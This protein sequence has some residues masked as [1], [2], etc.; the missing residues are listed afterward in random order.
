MK[1]LC[2][3]SVISEFGGVEYA[4]MN[5]ARGL[6]DRGHEVHF[7]GAQGQRTNLG[8]GLDENLTDHFDELR[9]IWFHQRKFP[10][11]FR[12]GE[13]HNLADKVIWH[14]RDVA[15]PIN[16]RIFNEVL[17]QVAPDVIVL[18]NLTAV[19]KNIWRPIRES[20]IPCM[21]WV[22]DLGLICFNMS[23]FRHGKQC[24]GLCTACR[25]QKW[26]RFS[27]ISGAKNFAFVAPSY[28]TLKDTENYAN[29]A[30]WRRVVIP[31]PNRYIVKPRARPSEG[32]SPRLLYVGRLDPSKGVEPMLHAAE[33]ARGK[34]KFNLDVLGAG[35]IGDALI[36]K[37]S[38]LEWIKFHG[39]VDQ[40][41]VA[42]FMS[43]AVALLVPSVWREAYGI[44]AA[45]ALFAGLPVLASRI[46]GLP[47][48]IS[49]RQTG[50]LLPPGDETAWADAI[51]ET[52]TNVEQ[53]DAWSAACLN[54]A[55][56]LDPDLLIDACENLLEEMLAEACGA[57]MRSA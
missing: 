28:A 56:R 33:R 38:K 15:D 7:L 12:L 22:H 52:L 50:R 17:Q 30:A 57:T 19:G 31:C 43:R 21:Q 23:R 39:S 54:A 8:P 51:I 25:I 49:D 46:G 20:E 13:R 1:I 40:E 37:Y 4:A 11:P 3:H 29:L 10:R 41:T 35:T 48:L 36:Q 18:H 14:L 26:F 16:E 24:S 45:H 2:V 27:L 53:T 32:Q 6:A 47:E 42:D 44:V 55:R 34:I 5:L 9:K